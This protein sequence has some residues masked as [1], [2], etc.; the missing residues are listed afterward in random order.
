MIQLD[1][2]YSLWYKCFFS[3]MSYNFADYFEMTIK[4]NMHWGC[5]FLLKKKHKNKQ[6]QK[7][8]KKKKS[9]ELKKIKLHLVLWV[10]L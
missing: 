1:S 7:K 4:R 10:S 8:N 3:K 6:K 2:V 5:M 9:N